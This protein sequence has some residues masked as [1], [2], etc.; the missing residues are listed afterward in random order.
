MSECPKCGSADAADSPEPRAMKCKNC[1]ISYRVPR[2]FL[3]DGGGELLPPRKGGSSL[4][5]AI[6]DDQAINS[7]KT[8]L[9]SLGREQHRPIARATRR[10]YRRDTVYCACGCGARLEE[11]TTNSRARWS[12]YVKGHNNRKKS[13]PPSGA[14]A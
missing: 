14:A 1:G 4:C 6:E 5:D 10:L 13:K 7:S 2:S 9:W 12:R 8:I 11:L 3:E